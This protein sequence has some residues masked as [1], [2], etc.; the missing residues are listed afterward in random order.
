MKKT[1]KKGRQVGKWAGCL[2]SILFVTAYSLIVL[3]FLN[4]G[5]SFNH[6]GTL[7]IFAIAMTLCLINI[8]RI[9]GFYQKH[10]KV[11]NILMII[12][13]V[14][15]FV[16]R[17]SLLT[18]Q[19]N[20][21]IKEPLSDTGIH[22]FGAQQIV[23]KGQFDQQIGDYERLF[24]YLSAYTGV[25]AVSMS[26]FGEDYSAI[27]FLNIFFDVI[28]CVTIYF[29]F[30]VWKQRRD[31]ALLAATIWAINP[32]QIMFC[33]LPLAI[34]VV[35]TIVILS[36]LSVML[37]F[38][39]KDSLVK[40]GAFS[41]LSGLIFALGNAFRPVFVIFLIATVVVWGLIALNDKTK[42]KAAALSCL[43]L[44]LGYFLVGMVPSVI[45]AQ[46]NPYYH[47]EKARAGWGVYVG[48]NYET[49]G[50]WNPDDR[51]TFFGQV[52]VEQAG[53]D[54]EEAQSIIMKSAIKRYTDIV[55]Q[56]KLLQH[57]F[58][59]TTLTFGD[60]KNATYDYGYVFGTTKDN[61]AYRLVQDLVLMF[62]SA[63]LIVVGYNLCLRFKRKEYV[64]EEDTMN[65][66]LVL[67]VGLFAAFLLVEAMNRYS[68]PFV[69][70]LL[71][72]A[73]GFAGKKKSLRV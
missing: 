72:I 9:V 68:L 53:G 36:I 6:V 49:K 19:G 39:S 10:T 13:I 26:I 21:S 66:L 61:E 37:L 12:L 24:P 64:F 46:F 70:I 44:V 51:D 41:L 27:L 43:V 1:D 52:L 50:K 8:K 3:A 40:V 69:A 55:G 38:K 58:N 23:E 73:L 32:L 25:L 2:I 35:N 33:G 20:L 22:W 59:K 47:G 48:S 60:V 57:F 14:L 31:V 30:F 28:A 4:E 62:Y 16:A 63:V 34:V 65:Y 56:E 54:Y 67:L 29:L 7:V 5:L 11:I 18:M 17:F 71:I 15:G 42:L 45:H